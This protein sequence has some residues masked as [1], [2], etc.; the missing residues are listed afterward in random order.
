[1][2]RPQSHGD[3][4]HASMIGA[5]VTAVPPFFAYWQ[6]QLCDRSQTSNLVNGTVPAESLETLQ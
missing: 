5:A 4:R 2:T 6:P 3:L 1:M